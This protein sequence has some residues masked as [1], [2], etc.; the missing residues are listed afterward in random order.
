MSGAYD[1]DA[2]RAE[3]VGRVVGASRGRY[4][5]EHDPI[6]RWCHMVGDTN[7]L[8]LDLDAAASGPHGAVIAPLT[9]VP[10]FA[11]NGPWP[12]RRNRGEDAPPGFTLGVPTP[13]DRGINMGV[14]WEYLVPVRVGDWL[15]AEVRIADVF[16][17]AIRL[18]PEA[19]W[20]VSDTEIFN[21]ADVKVVVM[22]NT[23]LVHRAPEQIGAAT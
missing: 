5:V 21:Q 11:G 16:V 7:P 18:D 17:K 22:R 3:W 6:R 8:Y 2:V 23:L 1:I 13:G 20:I 19:V 10:Y 15:R 4:P 9:L 12:R 14:A